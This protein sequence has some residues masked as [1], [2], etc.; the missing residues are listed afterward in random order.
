MLEFDEF[1]EYVVKPKHY[2]TRPHTETK[3]IIGYILDGKEDVLTLEQGHYLA[4]A[5]KYLDRFTFKGTPI[6][7]LQKAVVYIQY[8]IE[9]L[10]DK[11]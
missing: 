3:D 5:I 9:S 11:K 4:T 8:I 1:G 2:N 10:E 6:M 7:D